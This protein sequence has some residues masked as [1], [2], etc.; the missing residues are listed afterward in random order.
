M[1]RFLF[2]LF[3]VVPVLE[4]WLLIQ[5]GSV[6]GAGLTVGIVILTGF[7]GA[8]LAKREGLRTMLQIRE[9]SQRGLLPTEAMFDGMAIFLGGA[10]LLTPGFVTDALG[11]I[12]L[13]PPS[14]EFLRGWF[15]EVLKRQMASGHVYV[16]TSEFNA[17]GIPH[18]GG[19]PSADPR[20][21]DQTLE[22]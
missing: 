3:V 15:A 2:L 22:D 16:H 8:S 21:Y 18:Q 1:L 10:L 14:R 5:A 11:F 6:L 9:A 13:I 20:I 12:L 17:N 19:R 4:L 7:V